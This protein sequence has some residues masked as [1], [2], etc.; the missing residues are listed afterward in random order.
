MNILVLRFD[1]LINRMLML[2]VWVCI[3]VYI[4][5]GLMNSEFVRSDTTLYSNFE[6][7]WL[8]VPILVF[9]TAGVCSLTITYELIG[10]DW[11]DIIMNVVAAQ[12]YWNENFF[13]D[14]MEN[15]TIIDPLITHRCTDE[16]WAIGATTL[17]VLHSLSIKEERYHTDCIP[18]KYIVHDYINYVDRLIWITC[19]EL[20][21]YRH[22]G[23]VIRMEIE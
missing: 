4:C 23:I 17:D 1:D 11:A 7:V 3:V 22:S 12:W 15:S 9:I 14:G 18:R 19:Q 8:F 21:G 20:C 2:N 10:I 16:K 6:V 5:S 13:L